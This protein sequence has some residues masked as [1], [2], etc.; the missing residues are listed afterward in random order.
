MSGGKEI[1]NSNIQIIPAILKKNI[2]VTGGLGYIGSHTVV[3]LLQAGFNV[4][5]A[6]NLSNS[7]HFVLSR[8]QQI[9][10][11]EPVFFQVDLCDNEA[12][13]NIFQQHKIDA[14]IHFAALKSVS[15]SVV[16]PLMYY[17]NNLSSLINILL[18]M[19]KYLVKHIVFSSSAT[20][21]GEPDHLPVTESSPFKKALSAYG[22]TKQM[23]EEILEHAAADGSINAIVLRYFNPVGAHESALIGELPKGIPNNLMPFITQ[24][25]IGKRE[26]LT[27]FGD[28]YN[29]PDGT[30]IRDFIHVVDL[31]KAHILATERLVNNK[32]ELAFDIFNLG[33][34]NGFSVMQLINAFQQVT[35]TKLNYEIGKRRAGDIESTYA[36]A[37]KANAVLKWKAELGLEEMIASS[38]AWEVKLQA[39]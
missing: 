20:V 32:N 5:I 6:D 29:T 4:I 2:L 33:T 1:G 7:E 13:E 27:V 22:S 26:K 17:Q 9:T 3:A 14:V 38:W 36:D 24:T 30:C 39:K 8:I 28:D 16:N 25:G 15:E 37:S 35:G 11:K 23:G 19:K 12:A 34:G 18:L 31:A 10:K 21:Y